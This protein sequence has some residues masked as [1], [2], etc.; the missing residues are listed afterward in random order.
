MDS[1]L[2]AVSLPWLFMGTISGVCSY[3]IVPVLVDESLQTVEQYR[4]AC[5][6]LFMCLIVLAVVEKLDML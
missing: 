4:E 3:A 6:R 5:G 1:Y 2:V